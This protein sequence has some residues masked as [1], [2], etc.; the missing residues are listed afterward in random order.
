MCLDKLY[1]GIKLVVRI[2]FYAVVIVI[3]VRMF[4]FESFKI[5]S[6]SMEPT[7]KKSDMVIANKI[8][9]GP[10]ILSLTNDKIIKAYRLKGVRN[11]VRND[12]IIF[13]Y[14]YC[15]D[16]IT[17]NE[18]RSMNL[19]QYYIKRC[20]ALP[21]DTVRIH[22]G[23]CKING[24]VVDGI[25]DNQKLL[26]EKLKHIIPDKY[27][28]WTLANWGPY[29]VPKSNDIVKLT[30]NNIGLYQDII[31]YETNK[32]IKI[33]E[34]FVFLDKSQIKEYRFVNNY[35]FVMGDNIFDSYDSRYW[36]VLPENHI[37]GKI[38][39]IWSTRNNYPYW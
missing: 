21:G 33:Q 38:D 16:T 19:N 25:Y 18:I 11:V 30:K 36:G 5:A 13:N 31:E 14:P 35:Y 8:I 15:I 24:N 28:H 32:K 12:I 10:R 39:F 2:C 17:G 26:L 22:D 34:D 20:V 9:Y 37:I 27:N 23:I 7:L 6:S 29:Y 4:F 3:I 1:K